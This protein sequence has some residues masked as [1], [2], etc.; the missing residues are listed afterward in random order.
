MAAP[1]WQE[2]VLRRLQ[3]RNRAQVEPFARMIEGCEWSFGRELS[4]KV[5]DH[6]SSIR[7]KV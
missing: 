2:E 5:D 1:P 3:E 7:G 4:L 6:V